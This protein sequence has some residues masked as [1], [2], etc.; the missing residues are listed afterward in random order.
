MIPPT[1][2]GMGTKSKAA[3]YA[4][5]GDL[6]RGPMMRTSSADRGMDYSNAGGRMTP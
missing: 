2:G 1:G 6:P 4:S 5:A 3:G